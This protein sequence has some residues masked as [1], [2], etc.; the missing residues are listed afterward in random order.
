M[1]S[2]GLEAAQQLR[3]VLERELAEL[4]EEHRA[5]IGAL[6]HARAGRDRAGERAA[7][8]T[9]QLAL[10]E[11]RRDRAAIEHDER[12]AAPAR[13]RVERARDELLAGAGLAIDDD[14]RLGRRDACA[15]R[16]QL[17]HPDRAPDHALEALL[18]R[19]RDLE[20]RVDH[21][22]PQPARAELDDRPVLEARLADQRAADPRPVRR[23]QVAEDVVAVLDVEPRVQ[24]RHRRVDEHHVGR[25]V[26]PEQ[27]PAL[28][29][30]DPGARRGTG[31][32]LELEAAN[33]D[34]GRAAANMQH[35]R[36]RTTLGTHGGQC[37]LGGVDM[38]SA[39]PRSRSRW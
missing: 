28:V 7:L 38:R 1:S 15:Q 12:L 16:E 17:A 39:D 25:C 23:P 8:V 34:R 35:R 24:A 9:E 21:A 32:E 33:L 3:L 13:A 14:R 18:V 26:G 22:E 37:T 4:V 2:P 30:L 31:L 36:R 10:D 11:R 6:E 20:R 29:T 5:T 27:Q 19:E